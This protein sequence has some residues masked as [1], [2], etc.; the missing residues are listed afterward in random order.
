[1]AQFII[2]NYHDINIGTPQGSCLGPLIFLIFCNDLCL[3]LEFCSAILFADDT[4]IY[5]S[6]RSLKYL[7]WCIIHDMT[8]LCDWFKANQLSLNGSKSVGM[9]FL[10]TKNKIHGMKVGNI[11]IKFVDQTKFLGVWIDNKLNWKYHIDKVITKVRQ[12]MNLLQLGKKILNVHAKRIIYFAQI[13]SDIT[14]G[15][16]VWGNMISA[17]TITRLQKLQNKC[18][19]LITGQGATMNKFA[20]L[21]ILKVQDLIQLENCKFGYKLLLYQLQ[22]W[23]IELSQS[24]HS[25]KNLQKTHKYDTRLKKLLNKPKAQNK[26]YRSCIVYIGTESL[27]SIKLETRNMPNLHLFVAAYKK[28]IFEKYQK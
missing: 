25:G 24:D 21:K 11:D 23:I 18:I 26:L 17:T 4:T 13:Q 28:M 15:L 3:N 1:M 9:L 22:E 20:S 10:K 8:P 12:N 19:N 16:S 27:N 14:Y 6:H 5:K 2:P 7:K